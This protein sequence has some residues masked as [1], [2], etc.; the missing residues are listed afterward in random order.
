M[1]RAAALFL[2]AMLAAGPAWAQSGL[3]PAAQVANACWRAMLLQS[4]GFGDATAINN[5]CGSSAAVTATIAQGLPG[6]TSVLSLLATA[7]A[8]RDTKLQSPTP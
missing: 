2:L 6:L 5:A 3:T 7:R 1:M 8:A 4:R